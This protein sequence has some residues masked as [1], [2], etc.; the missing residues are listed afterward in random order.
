V[1]D[2]SE[3]RSEL[4]ARIPIAFWH[5]FRLA[6]EQ[7]QVAL[8]LLTQ[9]PCA[10]SCASLVLRCCANETEPWRQGAE[11]ALFTTLRYRVTIERKRHEE[12]H[13]LQKKPVARAAEWRARTP[14]AR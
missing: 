13:P 8:I 1:L 14:W 9:A 5:R 10:K 7:A 2:M 11:T 6:V 4:S 3:V 12:I